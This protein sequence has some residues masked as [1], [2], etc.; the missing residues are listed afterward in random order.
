VGGWV[1][2]RVG[3]LASDVAQKSHVGGWWGD[4]SPVVVLHRLRGLRI[5][6]EMNTNSINTGSYWINLQ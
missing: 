4:V 5:C 3:G 2:G 6:D 1:V